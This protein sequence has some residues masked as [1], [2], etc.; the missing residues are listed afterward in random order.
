MILVKWLVLTASVLLAS[1]IIPGVYIAGLWSALWVALFLGLINISLKPILIILTLPVNIL[2]LGLFT[3]VINGLIILLTSSVINGFK[4]S[5]FWVAVLFS[6]VLTVINFL[7]NK[8]V[9]SK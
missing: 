8:L 1:Y 7:L 9:K 2:T 6:I 3:F 5:G 4:V